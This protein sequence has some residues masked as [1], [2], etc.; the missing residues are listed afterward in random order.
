MAEGR[1]ALSSQE[2]DLRNNCASQLA[3]ISRDVGANSQRRDK[4]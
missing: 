3:N 1:W 4:V 2:V